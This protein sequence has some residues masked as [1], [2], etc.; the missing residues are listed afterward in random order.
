M[1]AIR[2]S[3]RVALLGLAFLLVACEAGEARLAAYPLPEGLRAMIA[4]GGQSYELEVTDVSGPTATFQYHWNDRLVSER[5]QYRGLYSLSGYDG[6]LQFINEFD[7]A[8][9][10]ALFPLAVGKETSFAG[11]T[12]YPAGG[13]TGTLWVTMSVLEKTRLAIREG[14]FAVY[15]IRVTT[16]LTID[17]RSKRV[18]RVLYYAPELGLPLKMDM[19]DGSAHSYWRITSL[20]MPSRERR[21]RLGT[22]MI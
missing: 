10:D 20:E 14:D 1:S 15:L 3:M 8:A 4:M 22:V 18:T 16:E 11:T 9:I 5:T 13:M 17:G 19:S 21:N 7:T 12:T 2:S 6:A